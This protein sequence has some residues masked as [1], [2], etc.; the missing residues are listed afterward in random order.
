LNVVLEPGRIELVEDCQ[1][2]KARSGRKEYKNIELQPITTILMVTNN[3]AW[4]LA[5]IFETNDACEKLSWF[6]YWE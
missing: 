1:C 3:F 4:N 2:S 6:F 5:T